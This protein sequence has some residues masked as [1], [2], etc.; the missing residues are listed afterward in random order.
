MNDE[1]R[2]K[3][4][5][6]IIYT[7]RC[8]QGTLAGD[9]LS[10]FK[11]SGLEF[12]Q[13]R[14]YQMGDDIRR[15]DWNTS[16]KMDKIM[17][18]QFIEE[19]DRN[20]ILAIDVSKSSLFS[21]QKELKKETIAQVA[22]A[23]SYVAAQNKDRIGVLFFSDRVEKWITPARGMV[24]F[25]K[26]MESIFSLKPSGQETNIKEAISFL[27]GLKK[28]NSI[29]FMLSD[30]ID[31]VENYEKLLKVARCKYDFIGMRFLDLCETEFPDIGYLDVQDLES[32]GTYTINTSDVKN[33]V[34]TFLK[35]RQIAQDRLFQSHKIDLLNITVGKP[36]VN[37]LI[38]FFHKR[39]RRQI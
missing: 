8:M 6:L 21:S 26:I 1:I 22:A 12:D 28:R 14:E 15:I 29:V 19:R 17:V 23:L 35:A 39:I 9:Y 32:G 3:I 27:I 16:A 18:K 11:G 7:K 37:D 34:Q 31:E 13:I 24:H 38:S 5:K 2:K 4:K 10:A 20:V 33:S 36:F 30:W 25:G